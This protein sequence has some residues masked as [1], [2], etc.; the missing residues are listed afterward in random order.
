MYY[1]DTLFKFFYAQPKVYL[2]LQSMFDLFTVGIILLV[3]K[4]IKINPICCFP[5]SQWPHQPC[6]MEY[7]ILVPGL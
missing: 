2:Q 4:H 5:V 1:F 3:G 6:Q 7:H